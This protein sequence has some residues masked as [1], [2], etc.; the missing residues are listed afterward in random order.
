MGPESSP[1]PFLQTRLIST[2]FKGCCPLLKHNKNSD[3]TEDT[4]ASPPDKHTEEAGERPHGAT[5]AFPGV[6]GP[7]SELIHPQTDL[8]KRQ[9]LAGGRGEEGRPFTWP[10]FLS[11][12]GRLQ[13]WKPTE[14][15]ITPA[16]GSTALLK[17]TLRRRTHSSQGF[18]LH[19]LFGGSSNRP[20]PCLMLLPPA[21][22]MD[23]NG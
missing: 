20:R 18:S 5:A 12:T 15:A 14:P 17:H 7:G 11:P 4:P 10:L 9:L 13:P 21:G 16:R 1:R 19:F 8:C 23:S 2:S 3:A 22:C 6:L